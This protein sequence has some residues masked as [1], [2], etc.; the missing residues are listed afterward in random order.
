MLAL[1]A[2]IGLSVASV[3]DDPSTPRAPN[4]DPANKWDCEHAIE[5]QKR[6]SQI[7]PSKLVE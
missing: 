3:A 5:H 1:V 4:D 2:P 6:L 7:P